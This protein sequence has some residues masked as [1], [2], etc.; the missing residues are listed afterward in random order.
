MQT[1]PPHTEAA[2]SG[3]AQAPSLL[4]Q[5]CSRHLRPTRLVRSSPAVVTPVSRNQNVLGSYYFSFEGKQ[6]QEPEMLPSV[7]I[8]A[9]PPSAKEAIEFHL[10][11]GESQAGTG[12]CPHGLPAVAGRWHVLGSCQALPSA[13]WHGWTLALLLGARPHRFFG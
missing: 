11:P 4:G 7:W 13:G 5:G 6:V 9:F 12:G 2:Q 1:F 3:S 10:S 8:T